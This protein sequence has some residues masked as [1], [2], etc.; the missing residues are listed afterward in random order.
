MARQLTPEEAKSTFETVVRG[1]AKQHLRLRVRRAFGT[2]TLMDASFFARTVVLAEFD[3][4]ISNLLHEVPEA[5]SVLRI[6]GPAD[7]LDGISMPAPAEITVGEILGA[8]EQEQ[9]LLVT[10]KTARLM[11]YFDPTETHVFSVR[12]AVAVVPPAAKKPP[13][14]RVRVAAAIAARKGGRATSQRK[15]NPRKSR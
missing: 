10:G 7:A 5:L 13:R 3:K 12:E 1:L 11:M 14:K 2:G 15:Q 8:D 9:F 6:T 4:P